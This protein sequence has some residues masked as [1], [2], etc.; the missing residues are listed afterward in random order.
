[1]NLDQMDAQAV[2]SELS[3]IV[4]EPV[5]GYWAL[6][7]QETSSGLVMNVLCHRDL[8]CRHAKF[9]SAVMA[10]LGYC[11]ALVRGRAS[12]PADHVTTL[13]KSF[14]AL[15]DA[16]GFDEVSFFATIDH[17]GYLTAYRNYDDLA[18]EP[19]A[20]VIAYWNDLDLELAHG[21]DRRMA[22]H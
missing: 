4:H 18:G 13:D 1:M 10:E 17:M 20:A 3:D 22:L 9:A 6:G 16:L 14:V 2:L 11:E 21:R 15:A 5:I 12:G 19:L 8:F 7:W